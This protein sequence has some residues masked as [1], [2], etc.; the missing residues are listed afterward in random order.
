M[1]SSLCPPFLP[2]TGPWEAEHS[3]VGETRAQRRKRL[4]CLILLTPALLLPGELTRKQRLET[5]LWSHSSCLGAPPS[6]PSLTRPWCSCSFPSLPQAAASQLPGGATPGELHHCISLPCEQAQ[7]SLL[8]KTTRRRPE[9][10]V[11][12]DPC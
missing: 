9:V 1:K 11:Q 12:T 8:E 7:A 3:L 4:R 6:A 10:P 5:Y 2:D